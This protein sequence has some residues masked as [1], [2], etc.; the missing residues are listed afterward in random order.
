MRNYGNLKLE[1]NKCIVFSVGYIS[2][3]LDPIKTQFSK[4]ILLIFRYLV[5][6]LKVLSFLIM[7]TSHILHFIT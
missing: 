2:R 4:L 1:I 6:F 7:F 5:P 3:V